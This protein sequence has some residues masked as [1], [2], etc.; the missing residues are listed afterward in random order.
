MP[1][2]LDAARLIAKK[3]RFSGEATEEIHPDNDPAVTAQMRSI[4]AQH[5]L[6]I[7][8]AV[9][10]SLASI[11]GE[12]YERLKIPSDVVVAYVY[13]DPDI[14]AACFSSSDAECVISFSS[15][16]ISLL[17]ESELQFVAGHEI[18]HFLLS[19]GVVHQDDV[20]E[21]LEYLMQQRAKEISA[22]RIG[23]LACESVNVCVSSMMKTA[24]GLSNDKLRFDT[25]AFLSQLQK[26]GTT[27][28]SITQTSTHPSWL[29][30]C[31]AILW[32]SMSDSLTSNL[33][34]WSR[35]KMR[36]IDTRIEKDLQQYVDGPAREKIER[37]KRN[38][39]FWMTI[40]KSIQ[41]GILD[42]HEQKV[43][44]TKFG[45]EMFQK[46]LDLIEGMGKVEVEETVRVKLIQAKDELEAIIPRRF[47]SEIEELNRSVAQSLSE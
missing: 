27:I 30:R 10:P 15:G 5:N 34:Y 4:F 1:A 22:D 45:K 11:L 38:Y 32:F 9:T 23:Y 3:V 44:S 26:S 24:S 36:E 2:R 20:P 6:E 31:R 21:S 33:E 7:S 42:K 14:Q 46:F 12:V 25:D 19:H 18:G 35:E 17:D 37:T 47:E 16:L 43:I 39:G 40:D 29:V 13:S 41:D 8:H 28:Y